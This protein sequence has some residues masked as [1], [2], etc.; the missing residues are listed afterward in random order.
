MERG[1][2]RLYRRT[3]NLATNR[4]R[5]LSRLMAGAIRVV[6][7]RRVGSCSPP[8]G[9]L[10]E[11]VLGRSDEPLNGFLAR[12]TSR[13]GARRPQGWTASRQMVSC[14]IFDGSGATRNALSG[15]KAN[16]SRGGFDDEAPIHVSI[17]RLACYSRIISLRRRRP[18]RG[19]RA[20][21]RQV[22][23]SFKKIIYP[24]RPIRN[25]NSRGPFY[26]Y[27]LRCNSAAPVIRKL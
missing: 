2:Q 26:S 20:P 10:S 8:K 15:P 21:A 17:F 27:S 7:V 23:G 9:A 22:L 18:P 25:K 5:R 19:R 16:L 4:R 3:T 14:R 24:I 6:I 13:A 1:K 11:L 12:R